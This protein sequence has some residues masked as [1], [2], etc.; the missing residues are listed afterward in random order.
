MDYPSLVSWLS[1]LA[2]VVGSFELKVQ[3]EKSRRL[4]KNGTV[5]VSYRVNVTQRKVTS[6][7][8]LLACFSVTVNCRLLGC[9]KR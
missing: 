8:R 5:I 9:R 7:L 4:T 1:F 2:A 3:V 6:S